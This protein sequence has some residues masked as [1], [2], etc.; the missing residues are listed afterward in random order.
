MGLDTYYVNRRFNS[1]TPVNRSWS[2][3]Y[4]ATT[5]NGTVT[6]TYSWGNN[7][8]SHWTENG[9]SDMNAAQAG[10]DSGTGVNRVGGEGLDSYVHSEFGNRQFNTP[11]YDP[12]T[13][14]CKQQAGQLIEDAKKRKLRVS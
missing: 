2:H 3:S 14:N 9:T 6:N 5:D 13:N 8:Q 10:V 7:W 4:V 1:S 11:M 12:V